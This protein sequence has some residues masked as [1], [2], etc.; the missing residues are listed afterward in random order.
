MTDSETIIF[1]KA[2]KAA[3]MQEG[4]AAYQEL[5]NTIADRIHAEFGFSGDHFFAPAEAALMHADDGS[6]GLAD[7]IA[8]YESK[9]RLLYSVMQTPAQN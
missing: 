1:E 3:Y 4:L 6:E 2:D 7:F 9:L 8:R 5:V